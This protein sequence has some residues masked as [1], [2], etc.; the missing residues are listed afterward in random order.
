MR[1]VVGPAIRN[2][3]RR[4]LKVDRG[5]LNFLGFIESIKEG[6]HEKILFE[7]ESVADLNIP[8]KNL[9]NLATIFS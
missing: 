3:D 2:K 9:P 5:N 8:R 4:H 7:S 6:P 1:H